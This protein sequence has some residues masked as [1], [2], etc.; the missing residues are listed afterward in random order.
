[1]SDEGPGQDSTTPQRCAV[2]SPRDSP[3]S[4]CRPIPAWP[5]RS[6]RGLPSQQ[7]VTLF[8]VAKLLSDVY[9]QPPKPAPTIYPRR[10]HARKTVV[11]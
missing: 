5:G 9:A 8:W 6:Y 1:M 7:I 11:F 2:A 10:D 4:V 3:V